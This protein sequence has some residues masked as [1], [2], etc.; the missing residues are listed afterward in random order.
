M[1][2]ASPWAVPW[3]KMPMNK[4]PSALYILPKPWGC[5]IYITLILLCSDILRIFML[6][7]WLFWFLPLNWSIVRW[8]RLHNALNTFILKNFLNRWVEFGRHR[9]LN[10]LRWWLYFLIDGTLPKNLI[11]IN[12]FGAHFVAHLEN[13]NIF[14]LDNNIKLNY[15]T[16]SLIYILKQNW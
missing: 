4:D 14:Y 1:R 2:R 9:L 12:P 16:F 6:Q 5:P 11:A 10:R 3:L 7:K 15:C 13:Y 8:G